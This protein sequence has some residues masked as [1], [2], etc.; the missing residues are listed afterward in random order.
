MKSRIKQITLLDGKQLYY[1]SEEEM[2][3]FAERIES[4]IIEETMT[5][6]EYDLW[7]ALNSLIE[8]GSDTDWQTVEEWLDKHIDGEKFN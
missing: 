3:K 2:V 8:D 6:G 1:P 5:K 7:A 4:V